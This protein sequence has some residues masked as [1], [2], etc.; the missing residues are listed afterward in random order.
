MDG[1][2]VS[3]KTGPFF[4]SSHL[5]FDSYKFHENFQKYIGGVACCVY[6]INAMFVIH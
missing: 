6:G 3:E 4:I 5:Y 2:R 1:H